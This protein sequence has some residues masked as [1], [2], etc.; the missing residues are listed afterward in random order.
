LT[1]G[2]AV[3]TKKKGR[4]EMKVLRFVD[5]VDVPW[6]NSAGITRDIARGIMG[7][8]IAW[9]LSRA[10]VAQDG[11]FSDF[12]GLVRILTVV[13]GGSM[14]LEH[15][16]GKLNADL[17]SPVRFSGDLK[18]HSRLT[19]GPLTDLN[20]MFDP[21]LCDGEVIVRRGPLTQHI[22][23]PVSGLVAFHVLSGAPSVD[24]VRLNTGDTVLLE[25][26]GAELTLAERDAILEIQI[27]YLDQTD[28]I[29]LSIAAR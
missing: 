2:G 24:A 15:T 20:L 13:A 27:S 6:K 25:T 8:H 12:A 10:D 17:W 26:T 28:A 3:R 7:E 16:T 9:R 11:A 5:L 18:I 1:L 19:D 22:E 23:R 21:M 4:F 14:V 29:T